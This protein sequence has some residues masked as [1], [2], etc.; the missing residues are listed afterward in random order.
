MSQ[1]FTEIEAAQAREL[2]LASAAGDASSAEQSLPRWLLTRLDEAELVLGAGDTA[3]RLLRTSDE[4]GRE[5]WV[6]TSPPGSAVRINGVPVGP[7]LRVLVHRD[8]LRVGSDEP[9]RF[10]SDERL[11][12]VRPF[13]G[14]EGGHCP[15]CRLEVEPGDASVQCPRCDVV[16]H[17]SVERELPCWTYA[18]TCSLCSTETAL[19]GELAWVPQAEASRG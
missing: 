10:F 5:C 1:I 7:G 15:R 16:Y 8:E 9:R 4:L 2:L 3:P 13:D 19:D 18:T 14:P 17:Q 11:A 12:Q 6:V